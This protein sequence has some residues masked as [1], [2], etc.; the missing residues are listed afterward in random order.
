MKGGLICIIL[1]PK[2]QTDLALCEVE[3]SPCSTELTGRKGKTETD[4]RSGEDTKNMSFCYTHL[5]QGACDPVLHLGCW[6]VSFDSALFEDILTELATCCCSIAFLS[7]FVLVTNVMKIPSSI[8][9][10]K[11]KILAV[12]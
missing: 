1:M 8:F 5:I 7:S 10:L 6:A 12:R 11:L 3:G 2:L 4:E 9:Q